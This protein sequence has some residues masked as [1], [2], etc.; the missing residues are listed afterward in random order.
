MSRSL[1]SY[2]N[3]SQRAIPHFGPRSDKTMITTC[4][5]WGISNI[6]NGLLSMTNDE[7]ASA[8]TS[9]HEYLLPLLRDYLEQAAK[10]LARCVSKFDACRRFV[11]A[12]TI[13]D[14]VTDTSDVT[15]DLEKLHLELSSYLEA[16]NCSASP[17]TE[18]IF[19]DIDTLRGHSSRLSQSVRDLVSV[20]VG[21][22]ALEESKKSIEQANSTKRI[23]QLAYVYLPLAF[24][25]SLFGMNVAHFQDAKLSSYVAT[26][27][28]LLTVT[29]LFYFTLSPVQRVIEIV[30]EWYTERPAVLSTLA[31]M[32]SSLPL[33]SIMLYAYLLCYGSGY[34]EAVMV[35]LRV[36]NVFYYYETVDFS[37]IQQFDMAIEEMHPRA[38]WLWLPCAHYISDRLMKYI[39][40]RA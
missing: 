29:L 11:D 31:R 40:K 1:F 4:V 2:R 24:G 26:N 20:Q 14:L 7:C 25:S 34:T 10:S 27:I 5:Q 9:P 17:F 21:L 15:S 23:S 33:C 35:D 28:V 3:H 30:I 39:A 37:R 38:A 32:R 36:S 13:H 16:C 18:R 12:E 19:K 6:V 8:N 22:A